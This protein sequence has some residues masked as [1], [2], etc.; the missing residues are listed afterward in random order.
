MRNTF[1]AMN[2]VT[3]ATG[4]LGTHVMLELLTRGKKVKALVRNGANKTLVKEVFEFYFP[5][6][7]YY[8]Q[9]TWVEGDVLDV[10]SLQEAMQDCSTVY[11][12][13]AIVSYH[14]A[15]RKKMYR[16]NVEGTANVVNASME[17]G[18]Q[19]LCHVSSISAL[20]KS[21]QGKMLTEDVEWKTSSN[22]SH[23]SVTKQLAEMEIWRGIQE[24]LPAVI[25]NPGVII[26][27]GDFS[28]SSGSMYTKLNEGLNYYPQGGTGVVGA[29]DCASIMVDLIEK[30]IFEQRFLL[31]SENMTMK[32]VFES[33]SESLGKMKPQKVA[34]NFILQ[35]ARTG[36]WFKEKFT[37]KKALITREMVRNT[38]LHVMYSNEKIVLALGR[39]FEPIH[40]SIKQTGDFFKLKNPG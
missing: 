34:S 13:A 7:E 21:V 9:I 35:V 28:R 36:E 38:S 1:A 10:V 31:I 30:K 24:G 17:M 27:P 3:G 37:G 19:Q 15:D 8:N 4:M 22:N 11:H 12:T 20:G 6:K 2:L 18:V 23:Y 32:T 39:N 5:N 26:G 25:V 40:I 16:I 33:V 14:S 29:K